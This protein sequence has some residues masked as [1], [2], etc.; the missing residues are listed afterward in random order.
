MHFI[1]DITN[2]LN[3]GHHKTKNLVIKGDYKMN[4]YSSFIDYRP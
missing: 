2:W 3:N 4:S 1:P